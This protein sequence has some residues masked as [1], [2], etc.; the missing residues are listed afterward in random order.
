MGLWSM[1]ARRNQKKWEQKSSNEH[2]AFEAKVAERQQAGAAPIVPF[3]PGAAAGAQ[4]ADL[5]WERSRAEHQARLDSQVL[6]GPAGAHFWG[7]VPDT[8]KP[9]EAARAASSI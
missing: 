1:Y 7:T 6:G 8:V 9:S 5:E 4:L 3:T 2:A